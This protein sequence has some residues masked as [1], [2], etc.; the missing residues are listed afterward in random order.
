MEGHDAGPEVTRVER[1]INA[2]ERDGGE[3]AFKHYITFG[4]LPFEGMVVAVVDNVLQHILNFGEAKFLGQLDIDC[5]RNEQ[6]EI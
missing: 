3:T 1:D 2:C 5:E 6:S 4:L